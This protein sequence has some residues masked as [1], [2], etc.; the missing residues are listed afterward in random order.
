MYT[1]TYI[2][3]LVY[4]Y[5]YTHIYIYT[6]I[7]TYIHIHVL[8]PWPAARRCSPAYVQDTSMNASWTQKGAG[9]ER[10]RGDSQGGRECACMLKASGSAC[11]A[12]TPRVAAVVK[13]SALVRCCIHW[14][15]YMHMHVY[16]QHAYVGPTALDLS[17][18]YSQHS[19][20]I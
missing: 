6:H 7:Y 17:Y 18:I 4:I 19:S 15:T 8:Q 10:G 11:E 1:Y 2:Q 16:I 5:T 13:S 12:T 20:C 14:R 9:R 3:I